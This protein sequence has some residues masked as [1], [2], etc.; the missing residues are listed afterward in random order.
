MKVLSLPFDGEVE[1]FD[2]K[3]AVDKIVDICN[4]S[5]TSFRGKHE[6]KKMFYNVALTY[7]IETTKVLNEHWNKKIAEMYKY[8][9]YPFCWQAQFGNTECDFFIFARDAEDF[10]NMLDEVSDRVEHY[11]PSFIHNDTF[12]YNNLKDYFHRRKDTRVVMR[13]ASTPLFI[14]YGKFRF[15]CTAQLTHKSLDQLGKEIGYEKLKGKFDYSKPRHTETPLTA[16]EMNYCYRDV[17]VLFEYVKKTTLAYK[18]KFKP[19][20]LPLA[21]TGFTRDKFKAEWKYT[22]TGRRVI[23]ECTLSEKEYLFTRKAFYG[24]YVGANPV[25]LG[26]ELTDILHCDLVSA[27]IAFMMLRGFPYK[28]TRVCNIDPAMFMKRL[29]KDGLAIIADIKFN[30][31]TLKKGHT[32]I[33]QFYDMQNGIKE[34]ED[35]NHYIDE[36][37]KYF[38]E[39][40]LGENGR[41]IQ[42]DS[43]RATLTDVDIKLFFDTYDVDSIQVYDYYV[44]TKRPLPYQVKK[45]IL[46][47]FEEKSKLKGVKGMEAEYQILKSQ[48]NSIYGM[49]AELLFRDEYEIGD[50]LKIKKVDTSY[51]DKFVIPPIWSLYITAYVREVICTMINKISEL[52]RGLFLYSDTDSIFCKDT[53]EIRK[54]FDDY[55]EEIKA[56]LEKLR[57]TFPNITPENNNGE[58]QYL[59]TFTDEDDVKDATFCTIGAKRYYITKGDVTTV[60]FSGLTAT[61]PEDGKNGR[62]T[63]RLIDKFGSINKAFNAIMN[64]KDVILEYQEGDRLGYYITVYPYSGYIDDGITKQRVTRPCS[65]VLHEMDTKFTL[66]STIDMI[67]GILTGKVV[68]DKVMGIFG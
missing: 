6:N 2:G 7:D 56:E 46:D 14:E 45:I 3:E 47:L 66:D 44:G 53:P 49:S 27:Y 29:Y 15:T 64:G 18:K 10:F 42:A 24:A 21:L 35:G 36:R 63:Q 48:L 37:F 26:K 40:G 51:K 1:V 60:T 59:G 5:T 68:N 23:E 41:L 30:D 17:K 19:C 13:N 57:K 55:N 65:C 22:P 58:V 38:V 34:D 9:S 8:F 28:I 62:N 16:E 31:V 43:Y 12:E 50:D 25:I 33:M 32:P 4:N 67:M 11:I 20:S 54:L 52:G 39:N 61:K